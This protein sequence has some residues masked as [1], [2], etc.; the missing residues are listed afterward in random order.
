MVGR[1]TRGGF[2]RADGSDIEP[3]VHLRWQISPELGFPSGGFDVFRR[4]EN[5][6]HYLRCGAFI[7][8]DV[9]GVAWRPY[10]FD[11]VR[12]G[13]SFT[14]PGQVSIVPGCTAGATNAASFPG[15]RVVRMDLRQSVRVVRIV[16]H[17]DT[18]ARPTAEAYAASP[19]GPVLLERGRAR[20]RGP[21]Y[22]VTLHG[23]RIDHVVLRGTDMVVCELCFVLLSDGRDLFWP[24]IP[25]NGGTPIYLPITHPVWTSPHS[26]S[27]DDLA[28]ARSRLPAG[29]PADRRRDY[30]DGFRDELHAILYDL[31]GTE[32]QCAYRL[33]NTDEDSAA[34]LDWLGMTLL[35]TLAL[36][37]NPARV[38]GLYWHD[39]PPDPDTFYDYR[40]VAHY[41]DAPYPGRR[42]DF[43]GLEPGRRFGTVLEHA[44]LTFVSPNPIEATRTTWAGSEHTGLRFAR[45]VAAAPIAI[46]LPE[47]G[48][49]APRSVTVHLL[50]EA[51]VAAG[52]YHG[53]TRIGTQLG[54]PGELELL[55][56][57][58]AGIDEIVLLTL[59]DMDLV[60]IVMRERIGALSEVVYDV[61]HVRSDT[62][63]PE[64]R[65][66]LDPPLVVPTG[67]GLPARGD[68][69][70]AQSRV[71]LRWDHGEAGGGYLRAQAP[72]RYLIERVDLA[73][74]GTTVLASSILNEA[75]PMLLSERPPGDGD[76]AMYSDP[77]VP[78]GIYRY[79]VRGID[80]F[81][82]LGDRGPEQPVEVRDR[83]APPPPQAVEATYLDPADPWLSQADRDWALAN[84]PG[85]RLRWQ[86]PGV[87]SLQAPDVAEPLGEFR[88]YATGGALNRLDGRVISVS[89]LGAT[90][91]LT[92]DI[93]WPGA[94]DELAGQ[95]LRVGQSFFT[96]S[97]NTAGSDCVF[98]VDNLTLPDEAPMPGPC[99]LTIS[100]SHTAWRDPGRAASWERRLAVAPVSEAPRVAGHV[101]AVADFDAASADAAAIA[102]QGA[103]RTV[104]LDRALRD[105]D[106]VLLPG[107]LLCDGVVYLA[108]GHT[109]GAELRIHL[110]PTV[111]PAASSTLIEPA[112]GSEC[113]Y[114]TGRQ[115]ELR[116]A[117]LGL[118]IGDGESAAVAHI[119]MS[120]SD[121]QADSADD[122]RWLRPGRGGLGGRPGNESALSSAARI[123]AVR[124]T[125]PPAVANVPAATDEP[126]V[127]SPANYYGQARYTLTWEPVSE[128]S[129]YAV[130]RCTG[131]ALFN[132]DRALRQARKGP[133]ASGSV[134]ADDPGFA[135]WLIA[136]DPA[137]SEADLLADVDRHLEAWRAWAERFYSDLTDAQVQAMAGLPG[138]EAAFRRVTPDPVAETAFTD[139]FDGRGRGVYVYRVRALD[140]AGNLSPWP[141]ALAFPP[142]HIFD[143]TPPAAPS[144]TS[145]LAGERS[146]VVTWRANREP[147]LAEYRLWWADDP[148]LVADVRRTTPS[149]VVS[150]T[151]A[152]YESHA[153]NGLTGGTNLHIRVAALDRDG[154]VSA[155]SPSRA[156]LAIDTARPAPP[157]WI[158]ADWASEGLAV[159][160]QW[161]LAD[162]GHAVLVQRAAA[163]GSVWTSISPWL[164]AG[165]Q[166]Y[167]DA[168]IRST[169][170]FDYRLLA[171]SDSGLLSE[172]SPIQ[173]VPTA[174]A[175]GP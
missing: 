88:A 160:L 104:T 173:P 16:F 168:E 127:A 115:Y 56:E 170:G 165:T 3:G 47:R 162:P 84:G 85:V 24:Q 5:Y 46:T 59:G 70:T 87:F 123:E 95:S 137:L 40:V 73:D 12:P 102:R 139:T 51:A 143:V 174:G 110:V 124:R 100:P 107:A 93:G 138:S 154:N 29:L 122:P 121:G 99:S 26:H 164:A 65:P 67:T 129:G 98:A 31:V 6:R 169:A 76:P 112:L 39:E 94:A 136:F 79:S 91:T 118:P 69:V 83:R 163:G 149:A 148:E 9:V 58:A 125:P 13:V 53:T 2:R 15:E 128:A 14:F 21:E 114:Y 42:A 133:Y 49:P 45:A 142:V 22:A 119:A 147:D 152:A 113:T 66:A 19:E 48:S 7:E 82:V 62:P 38:L 78:D 75:A 63:P 20:E 150:P 109:L 108:Y 159:E 106:H 111:A 97:G 141:E 11:D 1:G 74:D 167:V 135:N 166:G 145:V 64:F 8:A 43:S 105:P 96:V 17:P 175:Q 4:V 33:R 146:I 81:G 171:R 36:D 132:Q 80:L 155:P 30:L 131:A 44:G 25:L 27:P 28:E 60:S 57:E 68:L 157:T 34:T 126:I 101:V 151:G 72:V 71:D 120:S 23:D 130:Y 35:Q 140:A 158:S 89:T 61:F 144:I 90:S 153:I 50:A 134:F 37:P 55:F 161:Q 77:S 86:W 10:E 18:P 41:G 52:A 116:V 32:P 54:P 156:G 92:T 103:T 117:N 172:P